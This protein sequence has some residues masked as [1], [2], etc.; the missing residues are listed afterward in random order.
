VGVH[1]PLYLLILLL[2]GCISSG[3]GVPSYDSPALRPGR[4]KFVV[5]GDSR[6][7]LGLEFWRRDYPRERL[8]VIEALAAEDPAFIVNTGDLVSAGSDPA[9][10]RGFHADNRPIFEKGIP[11]YPGLGNHEFAV[12]AAQGLANYFA[13]FPRLQGRRWY[14]VRHPPVLVAIL[15][16]NFGRM[17]EKEAREQE[18]WLSGLLD[19]AERDPEIRHVIL[20]CHHAPYTNSRVH[21]DSKEV[22]VRL[23][24][25]RTP[26]VRVFVSGH[27]HSYERFLK[28]GV[29][30]VVSGGGGAP[31]TSLD[32]DRPKHRDE[33]RGGAYRGFHYLRFTPEAGRLVCDVMMLGDDGAWRRADGFECP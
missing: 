29:Q 4:S 1:G 16:S 8:R 27:V 9:E 28:D 10:W 21:P 22:Q 3:G 33:F 18:R 2:A 19:A 7:T 32:T 11:Y 23:A 31:L 26:K 30:Y 25:R 24:A 13:F 5:F 17:S 15:D 20:C 6:R 12:D 14:E